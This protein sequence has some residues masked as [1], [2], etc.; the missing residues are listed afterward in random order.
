MMHGAFDRLVRV[1]NR[2]Y[3]VRSPLSWALVA[4]AILAMLAPMVA[5]MMI[6]G[7]RIGAGP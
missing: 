5:V 7:A 3:E 1:L 2:P 6:G 4:L